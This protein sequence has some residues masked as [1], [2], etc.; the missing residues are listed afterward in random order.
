MDY[1]T[2]YEVFL[3][4]LD[5]AYGFMDTLCEMSLECLDSA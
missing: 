5:S 3:E 1:D 4:C 2:L